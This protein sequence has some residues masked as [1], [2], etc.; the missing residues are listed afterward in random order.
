MLS[1]EFKE[2]KDLIAREQEISSQY[3][4]G[5]GWDSDDVWTACG[6]KESAYDYITRLLE[7]I[8]DLEKKLIDSNQRNLDLQYQL[9]SI[10]EENDHLEREIN[11]LSLLNRKKNWK[12]NPYK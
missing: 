9:D 8:E 2:L 11:T 6:L 12:E 5:C 10:Y 4:N 7:H 1:E 3:K